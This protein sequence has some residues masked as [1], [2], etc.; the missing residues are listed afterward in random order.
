[1]KIPLAIG[2]A[3]TA[4][5]GIQLQWTCD[6]INEIAR[7]NKLHFKVAL[8]HSEQNKDYLV[9]K[10]KEGKIKPLN[11]PL[12]I[13]EEIIRRSE[14]IVAMMGTEPY[15]QAL[16]QGAD[17]ILAGRSSDPAIFASF[18]I[19]EGF[20]HGL[21]WHLGKIL[22]CGT[23]ATTLRKRPDS[24]I[25]YLCKDHFIV[26]PLDPELKCTPQSIAAHSL[27]EN[28]DPY[29]IEE[30]SGTLDISEANFEAISGRAVKV[31][32]SKFM[33]REPRTV[34]LEGAELVGYQSIVIGSIR[35]PIIIRQID[36]WI[37]R[38]KKK[39]DERVGELYGDE[40]IR[41]GIKTFFNVYG[42]NGTMGMLEPIKET[43]SHELC[44][45]I[46]VTASTQ[47][48]ANAVASS[49]RH[50]ALHH[51]VS[52]WSGLI[53][54]LANPYNPAHIERGRV[55]RFNLNHILEIE[56]P[57]EP[58]QIEEVLL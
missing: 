26:E 19:R 54:S 27:Y 45:I 38:L 5:S 46:E 9:K 34:K 51:P 55:Y 13:S 22:E 18:C 35:D 43:L 4:G 30:S 11:P 44:L 31:S 33:F 48:I 41:K 1:M 42:K 2:S 40:G 17:V 23:A 3:G 8:I 12:P 29:F 32:S 53:T 39:V 47:E 25:A 20:D 37:E 36:N 56:N 28:F 6:I 57:M 16:H 21:S 58:F 50:M 10:L 49:A 24:M 7:E 15:I 52:E 14:H